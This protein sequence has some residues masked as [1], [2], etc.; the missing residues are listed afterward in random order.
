MEALT[1]KVSISGS[2]AMRLHS[3]EE[4]PLMMLC[5]MDVMALY[6]NATQMQACTLQILRQTKSRLHFSSYCVLVSQSS[7][8]RLLFSTTLS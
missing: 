4:Y 2:V 5:V 3:S 7:L 1:L 8:D 6:C